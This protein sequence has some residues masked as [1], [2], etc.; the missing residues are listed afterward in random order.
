M[1]KLKVGYFA[2]GEWG[3]NAFKLLNKDKE[4]EIMFV[5]VRYDTQDD[6]LK[7]LVLDNNID[8]IKHPNI[9]SDDFL[10]KV[11]K[12][13]CDLFISMSFNQIFKSKIINMPRLRVI[14]CHAGKL[15]FYRGRN[16][17]NWVL[18]NDEKEF[19]ITV[20]YIDEGIDTGDILLQKT[21]P[22][23]DDDDY[24]SLLRIA[25]VECAEL[26]YEAV[27]LIKRG[28]VSVVKQSMI[29]PVGFYCGMRKIGDEI[30]NWNQKSREIFN[31][32]R[33][34]SHPGP[35]ARTSLSGKEFKINKVKII[36]GAVEYKGIPGQIVGKSEGMPIVKTLD[37]TL[38]ITEFEY[39][40]N[41]RI[42]DRFV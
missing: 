21:Y 13:D 8:Y 24:S 17:L 26:L 4:I 37:T 41:I 5:C 38:I 16:I 10:N 32:V 27:E 42:G 31:F 40:G 18:I 6:T 12:Y 25:Y 2:D 15:P 20:H 23:T 35:Q 34:I 28:N 36:E 19:G 14:N 33:S 1:N 29:H 11:R 30:L 22:I 7:Q 9:N 3:H 39:E